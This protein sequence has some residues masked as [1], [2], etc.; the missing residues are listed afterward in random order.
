[1][2][3]LKYRKSTGFGSEEFRTNK[4]KLNAIF[5]FWHEI[6]MNFDLVFSILAF[7]LCALD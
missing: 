6:R 2:F 5:I 3:A 7:V 1:M 4:L